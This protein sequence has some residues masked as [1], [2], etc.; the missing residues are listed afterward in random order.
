MSQP[1]TPGGPS[2]AALEQL[3]SE[4]DAVVWQATAGAAIR[5]TF[6]SP[7]AERVLGHPTAAFYDQGFWDGQILPEDRVGAIAL[8]EAATARGEDHVFEYRWRRGDGRVIW[9]RDVVRVTDEDGVRT[10]SGVML[11]ITALRASEARLALLLDTVQDTIFRVRLVPE[12]AVEYVSPS[13]E[14]LTGYT[15]AEWHADP[16]LPLEVVHPDDRHVVAAALQGGPPQADL[17]RWRH[18][19]GTTVWVETMRRVEYDADGRAIALEGVAR[20][21]TARVVATEDARRSRALFE[22]TFMQAPV[23]MGL[24]SVDPEAADQLIAVN[25][26]L[27]ELL[28]HTREDLLSR[29]LD[30]FTHPDDRGRSLDLKRQ[31]LRDEIPAFYLEKR[32]VRGDGSVIWGALRGGL[33][34]DADGRPLHG[35]GHVEDITARIV[36]EDDLRRRALHDGLTELP[37]RQLFMDR[38]ERALAQRPA[39]ALVGVLFADLDEL[40][41]INDTHGH[42]AGDGVIRELSRR[43]REAVRPGDSVARLA[44]DEFTV[45]CPAVPDADAL[46]E[47]GRRL[48]AAL[49]PDVLVEGEA[50][51]VTVSIGAAVGVPGERTADELLAEADV[52]LLHAKRAGKAGITL[53]DDG[54]GAQVRDRRAREAEVRHAA[55]QGLFELHYQPI[56]GLRSS[57]IMAVEALVRWRHPDQGLLAPAMF[58]DVAERLGVIDRVGRWVLDRACRDRVAWARDGGPADVHFSVNVSPGEIASERLVGDVADALART[59]CDGGWLCFEITESGIIEDPITALANVRGLQEL[60]AKVALDDFGTGYSSLGQLASF[61]VDVVKLDRAFVAGIDDGGPRN[62]ALVSAVCSMAAALDMRL[63]AEGIETAAQRD[64]LL[65]LGCE[66]GQGYLLGRPGPLEEV[67]A[68]WRRAADGL[69]L[70]E[71]AGTA[72]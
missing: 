15:P 34:R 3:V 42:P 58:V 8:C 30:D 53:F 35:I 36:H 18:R 9:I 13:C 27:C 70:P 63:I 66:V 17:T 20:D 16:T 38:L 31:L 11:D 43:F 65:D 51:D 49:D 72:A 39:G 19:N 61:P 57:R 46:L 55:D 4:L 68:G 29:P 41:V 25:D 32:Y 69:Y 52:A 23:G 22:G 21:V 50:I 48:L 40:K 67:R 10:L 56:A 45:L 2:H 33:V 24:T 1:S 37:N 62:R 54:L 5:F 60:G 6:V 26:A 71:P 47:L 59:G 12:L 64:Q 44:G 28:G 14:V 7:A